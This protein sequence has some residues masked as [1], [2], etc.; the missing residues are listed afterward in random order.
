MTDKEQVE[1]FKPTVTSL[2]K[3]IE[4]LVK[5]NKELEKKLEN[6]RRKDSTLITAIILSGIVTRGGDINQSVNN[7]L[8]A[9]AALKGMMEFGDD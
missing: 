8:K 2:K 6:F 3:E 5:E 7:A 9:V 4:A 1:I